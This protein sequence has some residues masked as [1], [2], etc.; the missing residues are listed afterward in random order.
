[1]NTSLRKEI[2]KVRD[3]Q[4]LDLKVLESKGI[5]TIESKIY[6]LGIELHGGTE[7]NKPY[8]ECFFGELDSKDSNM[9]FNTS[10]PIYYLQGGGDM[11]SVIARNE[12]TKQSTN[13]DSNTP[14]NKVCR[15]TERSEV[16]TNKDS[17]DSNNSNMDSSASLRNDKNQS[18]LPTQSLPLLNQTLLTIIQIQILPLL[19]II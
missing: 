11:D 6:F 13:K 14:H 2:I 18:T 7:S 4:T 3:N 15:H 5:D 8:N 19:T 17:I 10:K 9:G 12:M 16:S 1:M